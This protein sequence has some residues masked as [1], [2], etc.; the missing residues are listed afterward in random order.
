ML[1]TGKVMLAVLYLTKL[2]IPKVRE[3][4]A[5]GNQQLRCLTIPACKEQLVWSTSHPAS[6]SQMI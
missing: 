6:S 2:H 3:F 5:Y 1:Q 4:H